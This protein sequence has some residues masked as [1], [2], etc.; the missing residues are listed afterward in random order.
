MLNLWLRA[1]LRLMVE[2]R[3]AATNTRR[4]GTDAPPGGE[5][6][7]TY[8]VEEA[9]TITGGSARDGQKARA[10]FPPQAADI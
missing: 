2:A 4:K 8:R 3:A 5:P 9:L 6:T 7:P 10:P 1:A